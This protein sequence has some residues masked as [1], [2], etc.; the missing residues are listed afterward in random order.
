MMRVSLIILLLLPILSFGQAPLK[1]WTLEECVEYAKQKNLDIKRSLLTVEGAQ[2]TNKQAIAD[3]YPTL[4]VGASGGTNFG[5]NIDP[6]S[7]RFINQSITTV[8]LNANANMLLYNGFAVRNNIKRTS[9]DLE[10][11][12][13][14]LKKAEND[15]MLLVVQNFLTVLFNQELLEVNKLQWENSKEQLK[16]I[17]KLVQAG[18][19]RVSDEMNQRSQVATNELNVVTAENNLFLSV[20]QLK[21]SM[22]LPADEP[23]DIDIPNFEVEENIKL[24]QSSGDIY[25]VALTTLPEIKS[26]QIR[27]ESSVHRES[28]ARGQFQPSLSLNASFNTNYSSFAQDRTIF[29]NVTIPSSPI[30][31]VNPMGADTVYSFTQST[32]GVIGTENVGLTDQLTENRNGFIGLR[33]NIPILNNLQTRTSHQ[34]AVIAKENATINLTNEK[35]VLRQTVEQ[36]YYNVL[37]AEKT[38]NARKQQVSA[39]EESF[40]VIEKQYN[41]GAA[42]SVD[43]QVIANNLNVS[44]SDLVRA[45]Y[46][47]IFQRKILDFYQGN[48]LY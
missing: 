10:A 4:N 46:D 24:N 19:S 44:K 48:P 5:R 21:Q 2:A 28:S 41:L 12:L 9:S 23:F 18:S 14:D 25:Q 37:A 42:N 39:I 17:E 13:S 7:N 8:G 47:L 43:Y 45:K 27:E 30:G 26:A 6:T 34:Q 32:L 11:S 20:L 15:V 22:Q 3:Q 16:R 33:L 31:T 36:A 1:K 35:M 29:G 40:R 38:Y